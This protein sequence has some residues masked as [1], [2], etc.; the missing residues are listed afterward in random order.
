MI[1]FGI[2]LIRKKAVYATSTLLITGVL[3]TSL[4]YYNIIV[5]NMSD[6]GSLLLGLAFSLFGLFLTIYTYNS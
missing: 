5:R 3:Y 6:T 4:T 1:G 2:S